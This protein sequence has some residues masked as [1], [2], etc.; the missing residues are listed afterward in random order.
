[1]LEI[2]PIWAITLVFWPHML[3]DTLVPEGET[4]GKS[5]TDSGEG[6]QQKSFQNKHY[7]Y[8]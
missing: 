7:L 1:M 8:V 3:V 2:P 6:G 5:V 4:T